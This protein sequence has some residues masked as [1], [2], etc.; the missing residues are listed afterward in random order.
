M[1]DV[2]ITDTA[3]EDIEY[4]ASFLQTNY[5]NKTKIDFLVKLSDKL[6]LI[7]AMPFMYAASIN[8]PKVRRYVIHKNVVCFYEVSDTLIYILSVVDSRIN[9]DSSRF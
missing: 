8:N 7:E 9:P 2:V 5:S 1:R 3:K 4:I 6:L